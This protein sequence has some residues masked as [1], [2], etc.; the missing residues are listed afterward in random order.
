MKTV[1]IATKPRRPEVGPVVRGLLDWLGERGYG[2]SIDEETAHLLGRQDGLPRGRFAEGADLVVVLGGDGTLLSVARSIG[3]SEVPVLGVN[4]GGLGFLTEITLDELYPMLAAVLAGKVEPTR[5]VMLSCQ[6]ERDGRA[7]AAHL[8]LNDAVIN[9]G[10]KSRMIELETSING[11]YVTTFRA[12]GLILSTPTGSTAYSLAAGGPIVYPTLG[13][14]VLTPICPHTLTNRPVV[15]P[16]DV[17]IQ[18]VQATPDEDVSLTVDGQ[19]GV[20]LQHRDTIVVRRA[21]HPLAL[22]A[23]PKRNYFEVLRTKLKW[24]ER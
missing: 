15:V 8:A 3:A 9:K 6:V 7:V 22:I 17:S 12:D 13:A 20:Q 14:L 1:A 2:A 19:V 18:I 10:A 5:R 11:E 21:P 16:D 4:L 24:G 23:S